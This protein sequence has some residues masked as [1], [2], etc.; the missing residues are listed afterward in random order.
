[1]VAAIPVITSIASLLGGLFG[2][3]KSKDAQK[4]ASAGA[5]LQSILP[6]IMAL[7]QQQQGNQSQNYQMQQRKALLTDPGAASIYGQAPPAG[8]VPL[9]EAL[10]RMAYG[11]LPTSARQGAGQQPSA[12]PGPPQGS[13][14]A[15]LPMPPMGHQRRAVPKGP[16]S[17]QP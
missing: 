2:G 14:T 4:S 10:A 3:K 16:Q 11:L 13:Q 1:M 12:P 9:Q 7:L 8:A 15:P 6:Q 17:W 5:D